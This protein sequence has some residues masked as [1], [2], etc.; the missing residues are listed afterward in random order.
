M[1]E[2]VLNLLQS[3]FP[4]IDFTSNALVDDGILDSIILVEMIS[5]ISTEYGI[6]IPY[7]EIIPENFN[8]VDTIASMIVRLQEG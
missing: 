4:D 1:K 5:L 8:S 2:K 7:D 3:E 6:E